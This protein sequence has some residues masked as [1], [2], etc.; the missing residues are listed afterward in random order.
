MARLYCILSIALL[1]WQVLAQTVAPKPPLSATIQIE[2]VVR[3]VDG[4]TLTRLTTGRYY[5]DDQHRTRTEV[6]DRVMI[7]DPVAKKAITLDTKM[8]TAKVL[9]LQNRPDHRSPVGSGDGPWSDAVPDLG[10][11]T[12]EGYAV[13]GKEYVSTI[14]IRS[15][16]G[17][18]K[19]VRRVT[20]LWYSNELLLPLLTTVEDPLSGNTTTRYQN[21]KVGTNPSLD[22]FQ[23]PPGF[24]ISQANWQPK[25]SGVSGAQRS[26]NPAQP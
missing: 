26:A 17:N 4:N 24:K 6:D 12:I 8:R 18:A 25:P 13:T 15:E 3:L 22:L 7:F 10:T 19:P 1:S 5:R 23:V 16:L 9:D 21:L 20:R 14:P 11:Q 2:R